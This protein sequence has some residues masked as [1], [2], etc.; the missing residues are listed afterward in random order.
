MATI[1]INV[2]VPKPKLNYIYFSEC[3]R[4]KCPFV[5]KCDSTRDKKQLLILSGILA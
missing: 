5:S 2:G 4:G 1:A 3:L